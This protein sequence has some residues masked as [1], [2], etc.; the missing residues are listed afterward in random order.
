VID[1]QQLADLVKK[2]VDLSLDA[3]DPHANRHAQVAADAARLIKSLNALP[4][5]EL[6]VSQ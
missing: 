4:D 2:H 3:D 5:P 1:T 6:E